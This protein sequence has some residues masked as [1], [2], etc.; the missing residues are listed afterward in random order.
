MAAPLA[1]SISVGLV[2][3]IT[4]GIHDL[5]TNF[6]E[7]GCEM[8]Y[9]FEFPRYQ[10][11]D[12]GNIA[13]DFPN[14]GLHIYGEGNLELSGIPV[15]FIPGNS[16]SHKQVRSLGSVALR[17]AETHKSG[18][19]FNYFVVDINEE[20]SGLYGG[21]LQRQTE[22]V[23]LC[24]KKIMTF[25]KKARHPPTS[26]VLVGHSMGG[27]VA[28]GLFTLPDF[29]PAL[30][31]TIITQATPHQT[32]VVSL[33]KDLHTYY[34]RVNE[35]WRSA[36]GQA[37]L[38][39]VTVV[40]TGGGHR[41]AQVRYALTR[42]DGI[43]AEDRAV[44]AS[45]T[46][47]PK[48]WVSTDHRCAVWCR[49]MVLLTQRALFDIVDSSTK[50]ISQ[51]ADLRMKVF[52]HHF[53]SYNALPSYL[54][55][56]NS[57]IKLDPKAQWE[58]KSERSWTFMSRKIAGTSYIAVPLL[59]E[60]RSD[61]L[62]VMSN[63][64]NPEW[65]C[66][67]EI[68]S[69]KTSCETCTSLSAH[70]RLLPP[71]Y[72]NTKFARISFKDI[73]VTNDTH[74][75]VIIPSGQRKV[76]IMS[77]RYNSDERHLVFHLP[78]GWDSVVSY[79]IS[80]TDGAAMLKI[81]NQSVFYSLHLAGLALPTTAYKALI[82]PQRCRRHSAE[83]NEGSV[84]RLNVPWSNEETYSFSS[85]GKVASLAI[86]LQT[87]R[88]PSLAWDWHLDDGVEPHL[89]MFLHPYCHYQL[90]LLASA[91]DSLGQGI[92][93]YTYLDLTCPHHGKTNIMGPKVK[94]VF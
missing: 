54:T 3:I 4:Y 64:T 72:S 84:L 65:L 16:G 61:S 7:N 56:A 48:S 29:N 60:E 85:Y 77:D 9:M 80:A 49:Q 6:E 83:S 26:V 41:D 45:T 17:M 42:L 14:Y 46:A 75:V 40:S 30:V 32:P 13:Q 36:T 69:G 11:I 52:Q 8:T 70:S 20:L 50:Q 21:V 37:N 35:Y 92:S 94:S 33:D 15:L 79:P 2:G 43:V 89:E 47:V 62:L 24:V 74:I 39:H 25:Y 81:R 76:S 10:E 12:I 58:V 88:P 66:Y 53:L 23:H 55:H 91:P 38:R 34:E 71:L 51:D 73:P 82:L 87:P 44:S 19:H 22:F 78:N 57:T 27:I 67:C 1:L 63:L 28:R 68:P 86:K 93:I 5:L 90:R 59:V 31:N 18:V